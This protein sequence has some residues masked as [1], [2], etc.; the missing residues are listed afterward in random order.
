MTAQS[1]DCVFLGYS[2]EHK[3]YRCYDPSSRR[4]RISRDVTFDED[5][6]FFYNP[7]TKPSYS[8]TESTSFLSLPPN[9]STN[10]ASTPSDP[11]ISITPPLA[12]TT[13]LP[14]SHSFAKPPITRVY[15]R[16]SSELP[17]SSPTM[18]S[19]DEPAADAS[20]NN[21]DD[22]HVDELQ[23]APRYN[24]RDRSTIHPEEKY[25]FPQVHAVVD[26]PSTYQEASQIPEWQLAMS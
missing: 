1:V 5:R 20:N 25:G 21:I 18:A 8:P 6:P 13:S 22:S 23:V 19:P 26:E 24:L 14:P 4:I 2:P 10:D 12:P 9:S 15:S 16:R 3:G 7:S 17:S 11:L